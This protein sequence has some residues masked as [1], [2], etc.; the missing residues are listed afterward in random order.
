MPTTLRQHRLLAFRNP[1]RTLAESK[2]RKSIGKMS[3]AYFNEIVRVVNHSAPLKKTV[4][5]VATQTGYAAAG[6][7]LG[8]LLMGPGGALIG[9]IMGALMG[10]QNVSDYDGLV[11]ALGA[12]SDQEKQLVSQRVQA[13]VGSVSIEEL[14][15]Y[16]STEAHRE[17]LLG[18]LSEFVKT[19][20]TS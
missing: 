11:Y 19:R 1:F 10:Y 20:S 16:V 17:L 7:A 4:G 15:R 6:T 12:M 8:G 2:V 14:V 13:L 18:V 5:G 3:V 9:G